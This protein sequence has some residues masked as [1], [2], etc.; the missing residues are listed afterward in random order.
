[1]LVS[2]LKQLY[3]YFKAFSNTYS[4]HFSRD[5]PFTAHVIGKAALYWTVSSLIEKVSFEGWL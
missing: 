3:K 2:L 5:V 4:N 1:M